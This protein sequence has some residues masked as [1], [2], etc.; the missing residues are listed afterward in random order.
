MLTILQTL[1]D[2]GH[3][4]GDQPSLD[5]LWDL[6]TAKAKAEI[7]RFNGVGPKTAACVLM[8]AMRRCATHLPDGCTVCLV[9]PLATL[10]RLPAELSVFLQAGVSSGHPRLE[11]RF[12]DGMGLLSLSLSLSLLPQSLDVYMSLTSL[13]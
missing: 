13:V 2:E 5:Y 4:N 9:A 3:V 1:V 8:F 10:V 7:V 11:D 6:P 12:E